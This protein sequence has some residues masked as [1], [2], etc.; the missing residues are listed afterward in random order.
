MSPDGGWGKANF[1]DDPLKDNDA[2]PRNVNLHYKNLR[3]V[4][5]TPTLDFSPAFSGSVSSRK[6]IDTKGWASDT[7]DHDLVR[8]EVRFKNPTLILDNCKTNAW[9]IWGSNSNMQ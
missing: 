1:P 6:P 9:S 5:Y 3:F 8:N 2:T 4:S 7:S